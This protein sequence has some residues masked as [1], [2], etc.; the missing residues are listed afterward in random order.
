[1]KYRA[2]DL[3]C[4]AGGMTLGA[5]MSGRI[6]VVLAVNHWR[7]AI[8]T[9]SENHPATRHICARI[10]D[11]DLRSEHDLPEVDVIMGGIECTHHSAARGSA[12]INDQRRTSAWRVIDWIGKFHP[13]WCVF[14]NVR[15]F[16]GWG[17]IDGRGR[18]IKSKAGE[19]FN[20]W[21]QAVRSHGYHVEWQILNAA[22]YGEATSRKRLFIVCRRGENDQPF[23]WPDPTHASAKEIA[24]A[25]RERGKFNRAS[26]RPASEIIDWSRPCPSIFSRKRPLA[27]NTLRRIEAGLKKFVGPHITNFHGTSTCDDLC[28]PLGAVAAGGTHYGVTVPFGVNMKGR[29]NA[30]DCNCPSPTITSHAQHVGVAMPFIVQYHNGHDGHRRTYPV[31]NPIPTLDTQPRYAIATPFIYSL[32]GRSAGRSRDCGLPTP[33]IVASREN[34]G[35]VMPYMIDVNHGGQRNGRSVHIPLPTITTK[36]GQAVIHA[37]LTK[38]YGTGG[39]QRVTSPLDTVTTRHRHALTLVHTMRELGI[40]DVGFRMLDV[41]ELSAAQGFPASYVLHG[42]KADQIRQIGNAVCPR[43]MAAICGVI[44]E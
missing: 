36:R 42:S 15:E 18:K 38:Y 16:L 39:A 44:G 26:H 20:A 7:T 6:D 28:N 40:V 31:T 21:V 22:D 43:V 4:G 14:E 5:E 2:V 35:V 10:E 13:A 25:L 32:I 19:I 29:S 24:G 34:H 23:R 17:P 12:P 8:M 1:M 41:D 37:F 27:E 11:M 30:W 33:T 9:H 3:F